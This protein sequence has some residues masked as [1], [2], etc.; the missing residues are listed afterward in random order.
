M[1][2]VFESP[3]LSQIRQFRSVSRYYGAQGV[4]WWDWQ[5][6]SSG[7]FKAVAQPVGTIPGFVPD[8]TVA[9]LGS[10]AEGDV[11]VWAQEHLV[12]AGQD[13]VID[14]DFG[15]K[16]EAAVEAFQTQHDLPAT[17]LI[18]PTTWAALLR[19]PAPTVIWRSKK[20]TV[21]ATVARGG[22]LILPVPKSASL[23]GKR[24]EIAAAGGAGRPR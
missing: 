2:Q 7:D 5:E 24:D 14:G 23:P 17:G 20:G 12:E 13:I 1:G 16:T 4:S 19:Y 15:P 11:V 3:P 10:G 9:T 18:D 8:T 22:T 21:T 6:A